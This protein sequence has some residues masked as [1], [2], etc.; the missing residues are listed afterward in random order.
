MV[1]IA[2]KCDAIGKAITIEPEKLHN[3]LKKYKIRGKIIYNTYYIQ[4]INDT[5]NTIIFCVTIS[6]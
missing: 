4:T 2:L 3:R 6:K 5:Q 1:N